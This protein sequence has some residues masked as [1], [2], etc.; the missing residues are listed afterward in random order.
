MGLVLQ[1]AV[2]VGTWFP[3]RNVPINSA[4]ISCTKGCSC[5]G[6][7]TH[8]RNAILGVQ[9]ECQMFLFLQDVFMTQSHR[10]YIP[11]VSAYCLLTVNSGHIGALLKQKLHPMPFIQLL[12]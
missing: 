2:I 8:P 7:L 6:Q 11:V 10:K 12:S 3:V 4:Q 5:P 1:S 9:K